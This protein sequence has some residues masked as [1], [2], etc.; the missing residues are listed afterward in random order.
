MVRVNKTRA[1]SIWSP[2]PPPSNLWLLAASLAPCFLHQCYIHLQG[3]LKIPFTLQ[4]ESPG[5]PYPSPSVGLL[6]AVVPKSVCSQHQEEVYKGWHRE[7]GATLAN[8]EL[9]LTKPGASVKQGAFRRDLTLR[10]KMGAK[11]KT[12]AKEKNV[13]CSSSLPLQRRGRET[14]VYTESRGEEICGKSST[15]PRV[16]LSLGRARMEIK[17]HAFLNPFTRPSW[18]HSLFLDL[19]NLGKVIIGVSSSNGY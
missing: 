19:I 6:E 1:G 7:A 13:G 10:G 17:M 12:E 2:A 5:F 18:P 8:S 3:G 11:R 16:G 4:C 9:E 15:A 14:S